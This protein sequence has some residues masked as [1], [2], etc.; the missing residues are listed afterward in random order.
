MSAGPLEPEDYIEPRCP[1]GMEPMGGKVPVQSVPQQRIVEKLDEY[2]AHRDYAGA[3]RHLLYWLEEARLGNDLR[4][5]LMLHNELAGHYRKTGDK[6]NAVEHAEKAIELLDKLGF[7]RTISSGT[8]YVNAA[9]VYNAFGQN[10]RSLELFDRAKSV[11]EANAST[12]PALLGGLYNN[13]ALACCSL[14]RYDDAL[15]YFDKALAAMANVPGGGLE[16]AITQLNIADLYEQRDG[17]E[18]AE[19]RIY[20]L[21]D[22]AYDL[23]VS[24]TD[25]EDGYKAFVY[26]KCAPSFSYYGYFS[27]ASE[28]K[29]KAAHLYGQAAL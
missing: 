14:E 2:M 27:A 13:M 22:S 28:L 25:A 7:E 12:D 17:M 16:Q 23:L 6:D 11:Y 21:L 9:T 15:A 18:V 8:T 5:Q 10:E 24:C 26:E 19:K 1:L 20:E 4:G 29:E 3:E